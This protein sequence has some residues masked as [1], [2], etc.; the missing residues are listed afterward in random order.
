MNDEA[1][2]NVAKYKNIILLLLTFELVLKS[3]LQRAAL[4]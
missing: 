4:R 2:R 1:N 3:R